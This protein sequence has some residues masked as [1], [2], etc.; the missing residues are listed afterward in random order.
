MERRCKTASRR[1]IPLIA[2]VALCFVGPALAQDEPGGGDAASKSATD[3]NDKN[4]PDPS[5]GA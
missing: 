3:E 2:A 1:A 4:D 5:D